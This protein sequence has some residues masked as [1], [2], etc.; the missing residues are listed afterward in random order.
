VL[1]SRLGRDF[2]Q[3]KPNTLMRRIQRR[4]QVLQ[5]EDVPSYLEQL[6]E[7][8]D[9]P[10]LL[11]REVLIRVTQFF[12][13]RPAFDTLAAQI[14]TMLATG[15][16]QDTVRVWVPG[17]ATGEEAYSIAI[18]FRETLA[19]ADRPRR[20]QIFAT[21][22]DDKAIDVA[23]A[24]LY[25]DTIAAD[26]SPAMLERYFQKE[27]Q[28]YRV[29]KDIREMCLFST[30]D[31]VKDP[32]FSRL[33][34]ISCR[35][36]LIYF[37]PVLQKR[38]IA[39]FHYGLLAGGLLLLGSS[40]AVTAHAALFAPVDKKAR[41]YKRRV[42]APQLLAMTGAERATPRRK[43]PSIEAAEGEFDP[44]IARV[45]ARYTPA[46]VVID[47]RQNVRQFSGPIGK[48]LEPASG[49]ASLNLSGL[50][51][52]ELRVPLQSALKQVATTGRRVVADALVV[53]IADQREAV[54]LVVEPLGDGD[55]HDG[56]LY[57]VAF[58]DLGVRLA[59]S[60]PAPSAGGDSGSVAEDL[61]AARERLQTLAEELET[62][63]EELQSTN[64]EYQSVNEE[65]QSS[66]EELETSKEELE[67]INEELAT[68]NSELNARN[69]MLVDL[70]SDLANLIDSTSI[71]TLFLDQ[72]LRIRRFTPTALEIFNVREGDQGR[73]ITDIV[74][75]LAKNGLLEDVKEVLR[76][77]IP[78]RREVTLQSGEQVFQM[79]VRP[80]RGTNNVINGV[81][82]TF[83]DISD[84]T[85]AEFARSYLAAIIDSSD[86]AIIGEDLSGRVTSWNPGARRLYGYA[87]AEAVGRVLAEL[88]VAPGYEASDLGLLEQIRDGGRVEPFDTVSRRSDGSLVDTSMSLSAVKYDAGAII[89]VSRIIRD[90][91]KRLQAD[92]EKALLLGELDHRVKNILAVV[93]SIVSQTLRS[94]PSPEAFAESMEGRIKALTQSHS[95]LTQ[96]GGSK[97]ALATL[98]HTE[99]A[100]YHDGA[101]RVAVGGPN[102]VLTPRA[103]LAIAMAIHELTTNAA[104]YGALS[105]ATG[106]V[107]VAWSVA[108][109]DPASLRLTWTESEGPP[110]EPPTRRGFGAALIERS[111]A[112]ELDGKV[113]RTFPPNGMKCV[114]ELPLNGEVGHVDSLETDGRAR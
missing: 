93:G 18:L 61:A 49:A 10:E 68:L 59:P 114:I 45:V 109:A 100:P 70:N 5:V 67:S 22:I 63:N 55:D 72:E 48:Y 88:V 89:G 21:D 105:V 64:E 102:V 19:L 11:F 85:R 71:A 26:L 23:R 113:E 41:L 97:A 43:T 90:A 86:D 15:A 107:S 24:G 108:T 92:K 111:L 1:N 7:R 35:N 42:A 112:Y 84:R 95:L 87:D 40:E 106:R 79:Q 52:A 47:R 34:L 17:C 50:I 103:G 73:P 56:G 9:E 16:Q 32:P 66:N 101:D 54:N 4:M 98:L 110:V 28:H 77:L 14:P 46:F 3:Y 30:H 99:L 83:V 12:R 74:S 36:L 82:V 58:Q 91:T 8:P 2:S 29:S 20:I 57:L 81:V 78:I 31:L 62:S 65:L 69:E 104:K 37:G 44:R 38:V 13:D 60:S 33:D 80:Y 53:H 76:T 75:R 39:M 51:H 96:D 94:A 6:R 25:P 27:G